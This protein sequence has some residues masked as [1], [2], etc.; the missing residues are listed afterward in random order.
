MFKVLFQNDGA[1]FVSMVRTHSMTIFA[2]LREVQQTHHNTQ[3]QLLST[4]SSQRVVRII[5]AVIACIHIPKLDPDVERK[6][7]LSPSAFALLLVNHETQSFRPIRL[8]LLSKEREGFG[9]SANS[10][11]V[12]MLCGRVEPNV[13]R[14]HFTTCRHVFELIHGFLDEAIEL[15]GALEKLP[16]ERDHVT[17]VLLAISCLTELNLALKRRMLPC[18]T[19]WH[20]CRYF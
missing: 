6:H 16:M 11:V 7:F 18:S 2:F 5:T 20:F 15:Q 4:L 12:K 1:S 13:I 3:T 10:S 9:A 8:N 14:Y 19:S 17:R